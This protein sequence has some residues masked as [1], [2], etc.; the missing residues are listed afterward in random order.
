VKRPVSGSPR[1]P[2]RSSSEVAGNPGV[3]TSGASLAWQPLNR[4][5][6]RPKGWQSRMK[7]EINIKF[8]RSSRFTPALKSCKTPAKRY[9]PSTQSDDARDSRVVRVVTIKKGDFRRRGPHSSGQFPTSQYAAR[10]ATASSISQGRPRP[11]KTSAV[12]ASHVSL[13]RYLAIGI[14]TPDD[15]LG[16]FERLEQIRIAHRSRP[17]S[18]P[19]RD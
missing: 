19:K 16:A 12:S 15:A 14:R 13:F 9:G 11:P 8:A 18:G 1:D 5:L 7:R 17:R 4:V 3:L 2:E 10:S 6:R